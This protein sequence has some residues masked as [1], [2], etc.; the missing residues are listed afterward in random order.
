MGQ[1]EI[2]LLQESDTDVGCGPEINNFV[3]LIF[4]FDWDKSAFPPVIF[5]TSL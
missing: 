1:E 4:S 2:T 3:N 5:L